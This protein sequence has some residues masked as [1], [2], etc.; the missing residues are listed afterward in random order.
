V[1]WLGGIVALPDVPVAVPDFALLSE[2][3]A[4]K[5]SPPA[6]SAAQSQSFF[7]FM[8]VFSSWRAEPANDRPRK[9]GRSASLPVRSDSGCS[10]SD[11]AG[12]RAASDLAEVRQGPR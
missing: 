10:A 12:R 3:Q 9:G 6:P 5:S 1:D 4:P 2:A 7:V 11:A 8:R